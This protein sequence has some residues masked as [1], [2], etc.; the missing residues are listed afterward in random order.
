MTLAGEE[1]RARDRLDEGIE[2]AARQDYA[3]PTVTVI[4]S[5]EELTRGGG[6]QG[7]DVL[8]QSSN[9]E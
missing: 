7:G 1:S 5:L 6:G 2:S 9:I 3:P 8:D 4:G